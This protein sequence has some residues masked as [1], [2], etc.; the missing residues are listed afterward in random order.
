MQQKQ[1]VIWKNTCSLKVL[2]HGRSM[3]EMLGVLA[4]IGVLSIGGIAGYRTAMDMHAANEIIGSVNKAATQLSVGLVAGTA[5]D[6][7]TLDETTTASGHDMIAEINTPGT[8]VI[9]VQ[10]VTKSVCEN[11]LNHEWEL[12]LEIKAECSDNTNMDF[13]FANDLS[14]EAIVIAPLPE[15]REECASDADCAGGHC[16][17]GRCI[18]EEDYCDY[19]GFEE[20]GCQD[21]DPDRPHCLAYSC[22]AGCTS[23]DDCKGADN[24]YCL[25]FTDN[26]SGKSRSMCVE[27]T[28]NEHCADGSFCSGSFESCSES[29]YSI[30]QK[31]TV[32]KIYT[33][34]SGK[35]YYL[36]KSNLTWW[37]ANNFCKEL[38]AQLGTTLSL[39]SARVL[40][41]IGYGGENDL[42]GTYKTILVD[43]LDMGLGSSSDWI[44]TTTDY[45]ATNCSILTVQLSS[46]ALGNDVKSAHWRALCRDG[47]YDDTYDYDRYIP[48]EPETTDIETT[49]YYE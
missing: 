39:I 27:C 40:N 29:N 34:S 48:P 23:D 21:K 19:S 43:E 9:Q 38:G 35:T 11:I 46:G 37:E 4:V 6:T 41:M 33:A 15:G 44:W 12:P 45:S 22:V 2:E 8:F 25:T 42:S 17:Y 26:N 47:V 14:D 28:E 1:N 31:A 20:N 7:L 3:V 49:G 10:G 18:A 13:E 30:C 5:G 16:G 32:D 24:P 36:S